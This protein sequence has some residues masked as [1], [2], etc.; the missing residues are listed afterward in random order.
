MDGATTGLVQDS[1]R[2]QAE[3]ALGSKPVSILSPWSLCISFCF[4][5]PVLFGFLPGFLQWW[6]MMWKSKPKQANKQTNNPYIPNLL[7]VIV[8]HHSNS[9]L[10]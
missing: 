10:N 6:I 1:M 4:Q 9:N 5:I 3:K 7:F 2:K 8:F